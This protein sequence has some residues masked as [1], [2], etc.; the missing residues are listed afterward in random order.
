M[1]TTTKAQRDEWIKSASI[2]LEMDNDSR[3]TNTKAIV[4][5]LVER[6]G[7]SRDSALTAVARA[8]MKKRYNDSHPERAA[9]A[10]LGS[11][12]SDKKAQASR[13]N[14]LKGGRPVK[15]IDDIQSTTP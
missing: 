13:S 7:C 4:A 15:N 6:Y 10:L 9:A 8:S 11:M 14:G 1:N 12:T 3:V 5:Y 2:M